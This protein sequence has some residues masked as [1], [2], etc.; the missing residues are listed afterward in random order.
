MSKWMNVTRL[1]VAAM[2]VGFC[3]STVMAKDANEPNK[4]K[5]KMGD[6]QRVMKDR[7]EMRLQDLTKRLDLT[8]EQQEKIK[9]ILADENKQIEAVM[10]DQTITREQ[11]QPKIQAIRKETTT[12]IEAQLTPAQQ[13]KFKKQQEQMKERRTEMMKERKEASHAEHNVPDSNSK[14]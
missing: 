7:T 10:K 4:P 1:F 9:P 12:K 13:E 5:H 14:K 3:A 8:K 6:Q 11:K 2:V